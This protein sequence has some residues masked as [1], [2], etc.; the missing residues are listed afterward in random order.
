[1]PAK[2]GLFF[3]H[4]LLE[5]FIDENLAFVALNKNFLRP[6]SECIGLGVIKVE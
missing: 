5:E 3:C 1:M 4:C 2:N 6:I